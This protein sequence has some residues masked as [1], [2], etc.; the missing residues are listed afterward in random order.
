MTQG[1]QLG[2]AISPYLLQHRDNPV[3]WRQWSAEALAEAKAEDKPILLSIGYAAC[4]WCHVMAHESFENEA[5]AEVMN[6]LFVNIKVDREE[7]PDIDHLYMTALQAMGEQGGWPMTMFLTPDGEPFYGG[8]YYPPEASHGRPGFAQLL[9]AVRN[10]WD[11]KREGLLRSASQ[12]R[13]HLSGFLS[14]SAEAADLPPEALS[15]AAGR[16]AGMIDSQLGGMRGAPKFPN[17]P[18]LE[19]LARSGFPNGP[20]AHRDGFLL[21]LRALCEGGIF[22]HAGGGLHRYSTD[23]RWLVPHFEKMLYDQAQFLRHLVWGWRATG[24]DLFR[25]RALETVAFLDRE[26]RVEGG[27]LAA[28]LDADSADEHGHMEEGAFYVW[29]EAEIDEALRGLP[30][31]ERFKRAYNVAP[32]GNWEGKTILERLG[33]S[34]EA[35]PEEFGE[36]RIRLF[37]ARAGRPRPGRD[38]K[39]LADW[40]GLAIRALAEVGAAFHDADALRLARDSFSFVTTRMMRDGRLFHAEREG[41]LSGP[42]LASDYGAMIAA[43]AALFAATLDARFLA[44]GQ[45]LADALERWHGDGEGGH[46]MTASDAGDVFL[47]PRGD[48]DDAVA[49]ATALVVE[50]LALLAQ[51]AGDEALRQRAERAARLAQGR[52]GASGMAFPGLLAGFDRLARG[53]ELALFG[54]RSNPGFEAMEEAVRRSVDLNRVDLVLNDPDLLPETLALSALRPERYPAVT[55][56]RNQT[57]YPPVFDETALAS[58][59]GGAEAAS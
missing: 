7:R 38:D 54:F 43:A 22:D 41:R 40:N 45:T 52:I 4:H 42:A 30:D 51:V 44:E 9:E 28:S 25:R 53:S 24:D 2:E 27:G 20:K 5:V 31:I 36:A 16:I 12:M 21:T 11:T 57:C 1:N 23:A 18:Y 13:T 55:L 46:F 6:R 17:A 29:R 32:S 50:G 10:A 26:M 35:T 8:T 59:L 39:V 34:G 3:H 48:P 49:G 47:R 58:L 56:C 37:Q 15:E 14:A 33:G 19:L